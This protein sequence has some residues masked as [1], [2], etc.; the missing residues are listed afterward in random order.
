[1]GH[2]AQSNSRVGLIYMVE[3][4]LVERTLALALLL[5]TLTACEKQPPVAESV[6]AIKTMTVS[7]LASAQL[8]QFSGIVKAT[9]FSQLSFEVG[10]KV[11][12]V[13]VNI[14]DHVVQG[15]VLA[16]L[17]ERDFKL[18]VEAAQADLAKARADRVY[19][20]AE[21]ER[22][23]SIFQ[24]GAGSQR[25]VDRAQYN[26]K[27]SKAAVDFAAAKLNLARRDLEKTELEAPYDGYIAVRNVQPHMEVR[28]GQ[29]LF[30]IDAEGE[31][32]V[33][34][35]VPETTVHSLVN[36][37]QASVTFPTLPGQTLEGR[38]S[39]IGSAAS[40][41]NLFP[42]K[43]ALL[44]PPAT[45][46]PG[47]TAEVTFSLKDGAGD[48]GYLIPLKAILPTKNPGKG[49]VFI[50]DPKDSTVRKSP[51]Q[52]HGGQTN[53]AIISEGVKA[54]DILAVAGVS[55]LADGLKVKLMQAGNQPPS[56]PAAP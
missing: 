34:V 45:V 8:R 56:Q 55:F 11:E 43:V 7:D 19:K 49:F 38:I 27:A 44:D 18:D 41:G 26:Y 35:G 15:Q 6:R 23:T 5:L 13:R 4:K 3:K 16:T 32:E 53:M 17:D 52:T 39:Y 37:S 40:A 29:S 22:E 25:K 21:L 20:K 30:R 14:G 33:V 24:K 50:Y 48:G 42:V 36:G 1:M 31:S 47:M 51:V 10:G 28:P 54:G 2:T 46:S 9:D 12:T